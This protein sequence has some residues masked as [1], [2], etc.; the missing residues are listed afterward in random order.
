MI[1]LKDVNKQLHLNE[2][3]E[4]LNAL[5]EKIKEISYYEVGVNISKSPAAFDLVLVSDFE[6]DAALEN[7]RIHPAHQ[8]VLEFISEVKEDIKVVDYLKN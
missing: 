4:M 6:N 7:Y 2:L 1:K 8:Q 3:E 5:P